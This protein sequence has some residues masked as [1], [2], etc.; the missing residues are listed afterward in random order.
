[1]NEDRKRR[2]VKSYKLLTTLAF[3]LLIG[4]TESFAETTTLST[5]NTSSEQQQAQQIQGKIVDAKG[6]PVIGASVLEKGT[7]NGTITD[8]D[9]N[10]TIRCKTGSLLVISY[11]GY[12]TQEVRASKNV[13]IT[14]T[15]DTELLDEV[16]VVGYGA[17]QRKN[18]TGAVATVDVNK[19]LDS[20]PIAD[21]GRGLQGS[22][23]G[24]SITIP[25]AEVGT[26]PNIKIRGQ[27]A[28][29]EGNSSPLI[30]LDNVEIPNLSLVN[31]D[32]IESISILKDA[33]SS[34][35][36][37]SKAAFGVVLITSKKGAKQDVVN[38]NYS[39]NVS[40]Q[41]LAKESNVGG[42][43]GMEYIMDAA[44]RTGGTAAGAFYYITREG[45]EK[46]KQWEE[47]YG[48]KITSKDPTVYGRDWYIDSNNRKIGIRHYDPYDYIVKDVAI[49]QTHNL[50]VNGRSGKTSFNIGLGYLSQDGM[51]KVA[52]EDNFTRYNASINLS[53]E[54]NKYV[55]L[56]AG[57]IY[58][59]RIKSY[60]Y[61]STGVYDPWY[62]CYR[63]SDIYPMGYDENGNEL[64]S[65]ASEFH[66]ANTAKATKNY[67]NI[68]MGLH[69]NI[70]KG[71]T[72][73]VDYTH[74]NQEYIW[75]RPGTRF[76][77]ANT[78]TGAAAR[79][80]ENGNPSYVNY[81]GNQMQAYDLVVSTYTGAGSG[82][83]LID[84][85]TQNEMR[86]TIN[87]YTTYEL[88]LNKV[89]NFKFMLGMNRVTYDMEYSQARR[90]TVN[91][92]DNPQFNFATGDQY[93]WG[94][95]DW[96]AQL[97][98]FGRINYDYAGKY[99]LEANLR[100]DGTSIFGKNSRWR[101]YPSFSGG[102]RVSEEEFMEPIKNIVYSLKLRSSWGKIGDQTVSNSLYLSTIDTGTT[103]WIGSDGNYTSYV[104]TPSSVASDITWQDITTFD[105]G[106]DAR[107]LNGELGFSFD[108]YRRKTENMIVPNQ[109]LTYSY[110]T[111]SLKGNYGNLHTD[112]WEIALDYSHRFN[113]GLRISANAA[114]SDF[115]TIIDDYGNVNGLTS[116]YKGKVY[117]DIWGFKVDRLY[118]N[119]DFVYDSNGNLVTEVVTS[120]KG[121]G[122]TIN[123]LSDSNAPNQG[124]LQSGSLVFGPGDVKYKDLDGDGE[125]TQGDNTIDNHGDKVVIGNSTPRYQYSFRLGADYKGFDFSIFFQ[126]VGKCDQWGSSSLTLAGFNTGDGAIAKRFSTNYWTEE[127]T[128]AFYPRATNL[129]NSTDLFN[130]RISD[131]YLLN[132][133]YLRLKNI[134]FGYTLPAMIT[135][136][137]LIQKARVYASFENLLTFDH[138]D[139][140]PIDPE[141][142]VIGTTDSYEYL[143]NSSTSNYAGGRVG[144]GTP[145]FKSMS[146]GIQLTF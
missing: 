126:G 39:S 114:L 65:P 124:Y 59:K 141:S 41:T 78:W 18:L 54:F 97:G 50:S 136:K 101:W 135:K 125:I 89:H 71:W 42:I 31:P 3:V 22:T 28:S 53:T 8:I 26:E 25:S 4:N 119:T 1:M 122:V 109:D 140:T 57:A 83:D 7:T 24:L 46:S 105:I 49:S 66:Q 68:N 95:K 10:F 47:L 84:R 33:A 100:Y 86:N 129:S 27:M 74:S 45:I 138:L 121:K 23:P 35:I 110:G 52:K 76:T 13:K 62:Y 43:S 145:A 77:A 2:S 72:A 36:Y 61:N 60:P 58:S 75:L 146:I 94:D 131:R 64:R 56:K 142:A 90:T 19:T 132:M 133:A 87:A 139:G 48:G 63:W 51:N 134:T 118:Q 20:R 85:Y 128:N 104:G 113:N 67:T 127:N 69:F 34:S 38:V 79:V 92:L 15:E 112:G 106:L 102:W 82:I 32:D 21:V 130:M 80:D 5:V 111:S 98:Y 120:G 115:K 17:Q 16:V 11:I 9:G 144:I 73:D 29:I 88:N 116:Y 103:S 96:N 44:E 70:L 117:G 137:A 143:T 40:F 30:L 123:K 107:F 12:K 6:E 91:E 55:T 93:V 81:Y 14:L 99:L 108:W 37:G